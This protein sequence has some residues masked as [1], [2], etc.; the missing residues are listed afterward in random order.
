MD[1]VDRLNDPELYV[2]AVDD[3]IAEILELRAQVAKLLANDDKLLRMLKRI[4]NIEW[5]RSWFREWATPEE[6]AAWKEL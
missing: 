6:D 3:A 1:I 5:L 2:D 4:K